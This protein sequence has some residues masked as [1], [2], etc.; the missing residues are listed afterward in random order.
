MYP[1]SGTF[2][3]AV[4]QNTR[5]YYWSGRI[6]TKTGRV[7]QFAPEDI[8]KGSV[9]ISSTC[10]GDVQIALGTVY[11]AELGIS[12]IMDVDR[13][14]MYDAIVEP[15]YH[16]RL[17]NG[18][19]ESVPMGIFE[20]AEANR[21]KHF[22]ELKAYDFMV[23]FEKTFSK[24]SMK[25]TPYDMVSFCCASCSVSM[26]QTRAQYEAMTNGNVQLFIY[27]DNDIETY[28]DVLF[29][30]G[31][32]LG[33][34]FTINRAGLLELRKFGTNAVLTFE[35]RQ[36]FTSSFSDYVTRFTAVNSTNSQTQTAEY[37]ALDT[38]DG[39]TMNLG[40]NP[41][42]QSPLEGARRTICRN[43]LNDIA[44]IRY[45]PFESEMIG[46][47]ALDLGDILLFSGGQADETK[48]SCITSIQCRINGKQDLK[49]V[50][51]NPRL[52]ESK[53]KNDKNITG[54]I[55]QIEEK[56]YSI[57]TVTN[58]A[59]ISLSAS[60]VEIARFEFASTEN[61]YAQFLAQV[62]VDAD[63]DGGNTVVRVIYEQN[64]NEILTFY[65]TETWCD[66]KHLLSLFYPL[67]DLEPNVTNRF[68]VYLMAVS[69]SGMIDQGNMIASIC[70]QSMA[71]MAEWDGKIDVE[72]TAG[73][74]RFA[75]N[76]LYLISCSDTPG[77]RF[78]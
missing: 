12:L 49:C 35:Q 67:S 74:F 64:G 46:N 43:I 59:P 62:V 47:P 48:I 6:T 55:S 77:I 7:Y 19:Y 61:T 45:V 65:P 39:L 76:P 52:A 78:A 36:R 26:A 51:R 27:Q 42:I 44:V 71:A 31:Q 60:R 22:L 21:T 30:V 33:G 28:R 37:Y 58:A 32:V 54:L 40:V 69:G 11:A 5:R 25:G 66:G 56:K 75:D 20:V 63:G 3:Q 18:S 73:K 57:Q 53:S 2:L 29:Y 13:Y 10:C 70:G 23:R 4:K 68:R 34:F 1:V 50:G 41:L 72:E 24:F 38:D 15:V 16:L 9:Y 17:P 8:V 14:T